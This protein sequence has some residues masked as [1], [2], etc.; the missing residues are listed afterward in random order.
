M[1]KTKRRTYGRLEEL[2]VSDNEKRR[3]KRE[4]MEKERRRTERKRKR[5][6]RGSYEDQENRMKNTGE[7]DT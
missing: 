3:T 2:C 5:G 4:K 6:G 7:N 1:I